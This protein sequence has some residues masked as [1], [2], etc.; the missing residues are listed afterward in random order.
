NPKAT[1]K[2]IAA[3]IRKSE[4]TVKTIT[5]NLQQKK[6]LERKNGKRN[7]YWEVIIN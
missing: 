7:G 3:H 2:E 1:Q 4:R 6:L 5:A